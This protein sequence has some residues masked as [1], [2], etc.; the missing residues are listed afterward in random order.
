MD[1]SEAWVRIL[2]IGHTRFAIGPPFAGGLESATWHLADR[3]SAEGHDV[4]VFAAPGTNCG[5][6]V[7]VINPVAPQPPSRS[8]ESMGSGDHV[9]VHHAYLELMLQLQRTQPFDI[10][11]NHS[12]HY[13]PIALSGLL[14]VPVLT[15]LHTP[16]IAWMESA[17]QLAP[18]KGQHACAVSGFT[19]A[20]WDHVIDAEVVHNGVDTDVWRPGPGGDDLVWS[21][22]MVPEKAP[23]L[24]IEIARRAGRAL[25][26][27]G[28]ISDRRYFSEQVLPL[29]G[30]PIRYAGHLAE[31]RLSDLVGR[32]AAALVTPVW[33]E[34]FGLVAAEAMACGT[35]VV[36]FA[37]GGLPEIL[38]VDG[39]IAVPAGSVGAAAE[40]V[41]EAQAL[42]RIRIR[43]RAE[44]HFSVQ[45]M[46][47]DYLRTYRRI[48]LGG[49]DFASA[50]AHTY[51]A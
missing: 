28:P 29:L 20:S 12:L 33:D 47:A 3:L 39:G 4:T 1:K 45:R 8:M 38:G 18:A 13:L 2:L 15:T 22:R 46:S 19:A 21:G 7:T 50:G 16:P 42:S 24:A 48:I 51:S 32:C 14:D 49:N 40:A 10:V 6:G 17:F 34:P 26:L 27:A 44:R 23:H 25:H 36:A 37:R 43:R 31:D 35:P 41:G 30:G 5:P 11:H 9:V